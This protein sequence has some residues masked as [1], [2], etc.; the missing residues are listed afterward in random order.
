MVLDD[1]FAVGVAVRPEIRFG[2]LIRELARGELSCERL[3]LVLN[4]VR[5]FVRVVDGSR[6]TRRFEIRGAVR[7]VLARGARP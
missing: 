3:R 7:M 2:V 5:W 6:V 1:R 4:W